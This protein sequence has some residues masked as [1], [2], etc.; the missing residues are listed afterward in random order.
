MASSS[1]SSQQEFPSAFQ[2]LPEI[3]P[4]APRWGERFTREMPSLEPP[5]YGVNLVDVR[6]E[7][8][9]AV[10]R[11]IE[12]Q[13][14]GAAELLGGRLHFY[15]ATDYGESRR[16][17]FIIY[18]ETFPDSLPGLVPDQANDAP[19]FPDIWS[20]SDLWS[21][22]ARLAEGYTWWVTPAL[23]ANETPQLSR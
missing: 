23:P 6:R 4:D 3:S 10:F 18:F 17:V 12:L 11:N 20:G 1:E 16:V 15:S 8:F 22:F 2:P 21:E 5:F 14:Q 19:G 13:V 7:H 9:D